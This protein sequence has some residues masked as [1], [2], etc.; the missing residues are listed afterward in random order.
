MPIIIVY[1]AIGNKKEKT[2]VTT[3]FHLDMADLACY[4]DRTDWNN[5]NLQIIRTEVKR[6]GCWCNRQH[7]GL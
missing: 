2:Y 1:S 6:M 4:N 5:G 7:A 3:H